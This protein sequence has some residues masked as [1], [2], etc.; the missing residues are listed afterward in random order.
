MGNIS[1]SLARLIWGSTATTTPAALDRIPLSPNPNTPLA[2]ESKHVTYANLIAGAAG[3]G[4]GIPKITTTVLNNDAIIHL[5][6]TPVEIVAAV[7]GKSFY[8]PCLLGLGFVVLQLDVVVDYATVDAGALFHFGLSSGGGNTADYGTGLNNN[9]FGG[10]GPN[11]NVLWM[12]GNQNEFP[13]SSYGA[14]LTSDCENA[15]I[16]LSVD[17]NG[18]GIF[19]GGDVGNTLTVTTVYW[20]V[21]T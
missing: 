1:K 19:T 12:L 4:Y 2:T 15:A 11:A 10:Y 7:A 6:T 17:N 9:F 20:E 21:T 5:P 18:A 13:A 14:S 16:M 3:L 8:A